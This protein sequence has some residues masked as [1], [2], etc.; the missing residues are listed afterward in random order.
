MSQV[1]LSIAVAEQAYSFEHRD[2]HVGNVL[3]KK[4]ADDVK[5]GQ[6]CLDGRSVGPF[7][8]VLLEA[9]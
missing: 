9:C 7:L 1:T 4:P 8:A 6:L 5:V 3:I 2:L